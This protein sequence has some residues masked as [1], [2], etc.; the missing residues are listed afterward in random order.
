MKNKKQRTNNKEIRNISK[1]KN[2]ALKQS[3]KFIREVL[4]R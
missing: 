1:Y 4:Q 3:H 2:I